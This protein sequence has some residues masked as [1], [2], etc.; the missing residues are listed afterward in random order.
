[1]TLPIWSIAE[2]NTEG[3][4]EAKAAS[5][6][7]NPIDISVGSRLRDRRTHF[8]L[9][10]EAFG[11]KLR[12]APKDVRAYEEGQKRIS[13]NL[14][15]QIC[16]LLDV[17]PPYFFRV[18]DGRQRAADDYDEGRSG[19]EG[20]AGG[21]TM[22]DDGLRIYRAFNNVN[23]AAIRNAVTTIVVELAKNK[24]AG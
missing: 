18:S 9:S 3:S 17:D 7:R 4:R 6:T 8:G 2:T 20:T 14:L 5:I 24:H 15:L 21:A 13:A 23:N 11:K 16:N 22:L 12:I 19:P 10:E 1:M